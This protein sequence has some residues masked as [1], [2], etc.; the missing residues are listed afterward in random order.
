MKMT[1]SV[2]TIAIVIMFA[3]PVL[4]NDIQQVNASTVGTED[5]RIVFIPFLGAKV[6]WKGDWQSGTG[7]RKGDAV[8]YDGSSYYSKTTHTS[9]ANDFP[10][11]PAL[12]S[13]MAAQGTTGAQGPTGAVGQQ[14]S[15]G[16]TGPQGSIG[17]TGPQGSTGAIGPQGSTG[18]TGPQGLPGDP[19][20]TYSAAAPLSID[21]SNVIG[22]NSASQDGD[23]LTWSSSGNN[24]IAS[25]P[26]QLPVTST[27]ETNMQP[28][29]TINYIFTLNGIYPSRN[30]QNPFIAEIFMFAG[31]F[32][33][34]NFTFC[35]GQLLSINSYPAAYSLVGTIY[36][37]N[38]ITT[39]GVPDLRGR[40]P[41]HQGQGTGL[42]NRTLGSKSGVQTNSTHTH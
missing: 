24:W 5:A 14:G 42:S 25:R 23:V 27:T 11:S 16:D 41:I 38:G 26:N 32:A 8:F 15:I 7:Y 31:N 36:G 6:S 21:E 37:G 40:V 13:L 10:P 33:P 17:A 12:W 9:T 3:I 35:D 39:F 1:L 18:D 30:S 2:L 22:L 19:A 29:L 20:P 4:G 34:R 28:Y